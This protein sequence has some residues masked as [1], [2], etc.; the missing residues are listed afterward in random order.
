[1]RLALQPKEIYTLP[2]LPLS[3][4]EPPTVSQSPSA[5]ALQSL[6]K[7]RRWLA[8]RCHVRIERASTADDALDALDYL[9]RFLRRDGAARQSR[10]STTRPP[11][12]GIAARCRCCWPR[13]G[14]A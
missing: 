11:C 10:S 3:V 14:C 5:R 9:V 4:P 12:D 7:H 13:D 6:A 2:Y 1:M 8:H